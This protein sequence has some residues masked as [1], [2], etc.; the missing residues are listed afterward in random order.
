MSETLPDTAARII[1]N[2]ERVIVG[3][4]TEVE[5]ALIAVLSRGHV[6]IEDVPG[7]G[8][9]MLARALAKSVGLA[10]DDVDKCLD[11][12]KFFPFLSKEEQEEAKASGEV[13]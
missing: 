3:K 11:K 1:A 8:K 13:D 2:V 12:K 5:L 7:T 6:L 9:T 10:E 4:R